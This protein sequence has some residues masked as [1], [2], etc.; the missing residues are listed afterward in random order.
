MPKSLLIF[1]VLVG[2]LSACSVERYLVAERP[3]YAGSEVELEDPDNVPDGD[4]LTTSLLA[5]VRQE[6][7]SNLKMWWWFKL[8]PKKEKGV[9][10]WLRNTLGA[11]PAY[12]D[13]AKAAQT[14]LIMADYLK[15][16]GYFGSR[17][18]YDTIHIDSARAQ[19][20][21]DVRTDGRSAIDTVAWPSDSTALGGFILKHR[22]GSLIK[23]GDYYTIAALNAERARLDQLAQRDGFYDVT[24]SNIFYYVDSSATTGGVGIYMRLAEGADSLTLFRHRIGETYIIPDYSLEQDSVGARDTTYHSGMAIVALPGEKIRPAVLARRVQ[25]REGEL[26]DKQIYDNTVNQLLDLGIFKFVNYQFERRL[27]DSIPVLDQYIQLTKGQT[28]D[29]NVDVS[30]SAVTGGGPGFG[31]NTAYNNRNLFNGAEDLSVNLGGGVEYQTSAVPNEEASGANLI[32]ATQFNFG[33]TLGLPKLYAPYGRKLERGAFYIPKTLINLNAQYTLREDFD[34]QNVGL[35]LGYQYRANQFV[36]HEFYPLSATY[37]RFAIKSD[38]FQTIVDRDPR[39]FAAFRNT[40]II[41]AEYK[42]TYT[43]PASLSKRGFWTIEA[44]LRTSGNVAQ[45]LA[46]GDGEIGNVVLSQFGKVYGDIRKTF[47]KDRNAIATRAYLGAAIPYGK[48]NVAPYIEQFFVGGPNSMRGFNLRGLGPGRIAPDTTGGQTQGSLDRTGDIRI[49]L[50]AEYRFDVVPFI[51]GAVFVDAG[52]IWTY[53]D[54]NPEPPVGG[55]ARGVFELNN[56]VQELAVNT[57]VGL[58]LNLD[59]IVIRLDAAL[60]LYKPWLP[61]NSIGLDYL[62]LDEVQPQFGIGYPF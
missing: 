32:Q 10:N 20:K 51:E 50:N 53:K 6:Q 36:T 61:E 33:V 14:G 27:T 25:L 37:T 49:E 39:V 54:V 7:V 52:N 29:V 11:P 17:V 58:R 40:A 41:G 24:T 57:G 26:F 59:V 21:Y 13:D 5:V 31:V 47:Q 15:D 19:A 45:V 16:H 30:A 9:K 46:N 3:I 62:E 42:F 38:T 28:Q 23:Q 43:E 34:L 4:A 44:G 2:M 18:D 48:S 22:N 12:Y 56:F 8:Q 1:L 55:E 60:P 35:K